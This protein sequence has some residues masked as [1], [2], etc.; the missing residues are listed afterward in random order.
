VQARERGIV[1]P[2]GRVVYVAFWD[3]P[4]TLALNRTTESKKLRGVTP[5]SFPLTLIALCQARRLA[6]ARAI[7]AARA[8]AW[9]PAA[10]AA[11]SAAI[12]ASAAPGRAAAGFARSQHALFCAL[13]LFAL[14]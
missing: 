5:R 14:G 3:L 6:A 12:T 1:R 8:A 11:A 7:S 13:A 4:R 10:I 2:S 9:W